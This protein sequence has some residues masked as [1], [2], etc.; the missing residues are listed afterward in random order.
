MSDNLKTKN[1]INRI[2]ELISK[3]KLD[4]AVNL[5]KEN[6]ESNKEIQ[7]LLAVILNKQNKFEQAAD[8]IKDVL[9]SSSDSFKID[10]T[11]LFNAGVILKDNNEIEEAEKN[12]IKATILNPSNTFA[13]YNL[14]KLLADLKN[15][16]MAEEYYETLLIFEPKNVKAIY[17]L[18][19][20]FS[21]TGQLKKAI[22]YYSKTTQMQE[23]FLPAYL[24]L[25]TS[26][27]RVGNFTKAEEA[28]YKAIEIAEKSNIK[29][30]IVD[31]HW[32]MANILLTQEKFEKG[33]KE[34]EWRLQKP[35]AI[36]LENDAPYWNGKE[37]LKGKTALLW[38]EQGLGDTIQFLRYAKDI[39][40]LGAKVIVYCPQSLVN[41][42]KNIEGVSDA[43]DLNETI[44]EID[45]C[46]PIMSC[47][48][49][50]QINEKHSKQ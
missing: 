2:Y 24:N 50:L 19:N 40:N 9:S 31:A 6:D 25:A 12:W 3:D 41:L 26:Y 10:D 48:Y 14:A 46:I 27:K 21:T 38:H 18:A 37:D 49:L 45:F 30:Y 34:Y 29:E 35:D 32:K 43:I 15:Y 42:A 13:L 44:P 20:I 4:E 17:N 22:E 7:Y 8:I 23:Y 1:T 11:I 47:P 39:S 33:F 36:I 28:C 16:K 5:C